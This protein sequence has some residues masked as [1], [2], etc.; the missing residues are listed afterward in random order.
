MHA[1]AFMRLETDNSTK[2]QEEKKR[3]KTN[4]YWDILKILIHTIDYETHNFGQ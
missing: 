4:I 2:K 3:E 1:I